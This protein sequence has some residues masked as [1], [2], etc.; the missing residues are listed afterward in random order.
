M[1]RILLDLRMQHA[2][3]G[4]YGGDLADAIRSLPGGPEV[5]TFDAGTEIWQRLRRAVFTPWG[6]ASVLRQARKAGVDLIHGLHLEIPDTREIPTVVTIQDLIPREFPDS[7][8]NPLRRF[9]FNRIVERSLRNSARVIV[10]SPATRE[11]LAGIGA[12]LGKIRVIPVGVSRRFT[13][14]SQPERDEARRQ[15]AGGGRYVSASTREKA[16][17]NIDGLAEAA[18]ILQKEVD[19]PILC[20][21]WT[22]RGLPPPLRYVGRLPDDDLRAFYGG[23]EA[24]V[25]PSL[26]EGFGLPALEALACGVPVVCGPR[27]GALPYIRPGVV[28]VDV[29]RPA[30]IAMGLRRMLTDDDLRKKLS[31]DGLAAVGKLTIEETARSTV[32]VYREVLEAL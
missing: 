12:D 2:G 17:K 28:E 16:H 27:T 8:P 10:P 6:R 9:G 21:G 7:T 5:C 15:Y 4:R 23:A 24:L 20:S 18:A 1:A 13:P 31:E 29:T 30:E 19:V 11:A 32:D 14:L 26:V 22:N 3:V 25:L